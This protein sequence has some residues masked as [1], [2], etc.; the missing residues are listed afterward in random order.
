ML[1]ASAVYG[2][3][4]TTPHE[5]TAAVSWGYWTMGKSPLFGFARA[6]I[7]ARHVTEVE[8]G[9]RWRFGANIEIGGGVI[10]IH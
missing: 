7:Y 6:G 4:P 10:L 8:F 9:T 2:T 5:Y 3:G 1:T